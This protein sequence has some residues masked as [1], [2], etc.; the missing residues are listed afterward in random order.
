M[1]L[2]ITNLRVMLVMPVHRDIA[3]RTVRS[4]LE[5]QAECLVR[6]IPIDIEMQVGSSLVHHART[7]AAH[8]FLQSDYNRIFWID[9][10]I[11]WQAKDFLR[12][13]ALSTK[14]EC[15][16]GAYP[17]KSDPPL[18]LLNVD[19]DTNIQAN[20]YGCIP[21]K[22]AGLGFTCVQRGVMEQLA[23]K[24]P[25]LKY[26]DMDVKIPRVFRCDDND[27]NARGEDMAFFADIRE[28]GY[29]V[30]LDPNITLGHIGQKEFVGTMSA[31]LT[32]Q[33]AQAA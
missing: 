24:A 3:A 28:L 11:S 15:V 30:N 27:G 16:C 22:G 29:L 25:L 14:M 31:F 7:K 1:E 6:G 21:V 4:L 33:P 9:S 20:E 19:L 12:L 18:F 5:T 17:L 2:S 32:E 23:A 8:L 13:L 26:P 10:D